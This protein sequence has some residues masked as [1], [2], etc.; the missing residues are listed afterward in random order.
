MVALG[1]LVLERLLGLGLLLLRLLQ[2]SLQGLGRL[3]ALRRLLPGRRQLLLQLPRAL[4]VRLGPL[5]RLVAGRAHV[6]QLPRQPVGSRLAGV[7]LLL[8]AR[9][10][11]LKVGDC[12][13]ACCSWPWRPWIVWSRW[14]MS[15]L[16]AASLLLELG[17]VGRRLPA[18]L[19]RGRALVGG[20]RLRARGLGRRLTR[21]GRL[22]VL[23]P[24]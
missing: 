17:L 16:S 9:E 2:L 8:R 18:R 22:R 3:V 24:A 5:L 4:A 14:E 23:R 6:G 7:R 21:A 19:R 12:C 15:P 10:P 1:E 11:P 20:S 13:C